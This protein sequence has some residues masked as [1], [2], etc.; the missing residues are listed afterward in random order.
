MIFPS[1]FTSLLSRDFGIEL[2]TTQKPTAFTGAQNVAENVI[3]DGSASLPL[4]WPVQKLDIHQAPEK[5]ANPKFSRELR[6]GSSDFNAIPSSG[7]INSPTQI[8]GTTSNN[9]MRRLSNDTSPITFLSVSQV[10]TM[11][12]SFCLIF[13]HPRKLHDYPKHPSESFRISI[14]AQ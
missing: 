2:A 1:I 8:R 9:I 7:Q 14:R 5:E 11:S 4:R 10:L 12:I 3:N 13:T 6:A